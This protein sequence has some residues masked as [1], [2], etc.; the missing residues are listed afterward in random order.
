MGDH[1]IFAFD[2]NFVPTIW[3]IRTGEVIRTFARPE[4]RVPSLQSYHAVK[5]VRLSG[6][7]AACAFYA[8]GYNEDVS[9]I[10]IINLASGKETARLDVRGRVRDVDFLNQS[11]L[12]MVSTDKDMRA[13]R[14]REWGQIVQGKV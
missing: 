9:A 13:C 1:G 12:A 10:I 14:L 3:D 11:L 5:G 8:E 2:G 6:D 7:F 4:L